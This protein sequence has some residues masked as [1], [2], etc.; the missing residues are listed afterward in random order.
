MFLNL[1]SSDLV[2]CLSSL[3]KI[4]K[5]KNNL[6]WRGWR[7]RRGRADLGVLWYR[8]S[9]WTV[10]FVAEAV[11]TMEGRKKHSIT[12]WQRCGC[13]GRVK[14]QGISGRSHGGHRE[15]WLFWGGLLTRRGDRCSKRWDL[16]PPGWPERHSSMRGEKERKLWASTGWICMTV[17]Q[18]ATGVCGLRLATYI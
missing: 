15:V 9:L 8:R 18:G 10:T 3:L 17:T 13:S 2:K 14:G 4:I 1:Q 7:E 12:R 6:F 16:L 11:G 5:K